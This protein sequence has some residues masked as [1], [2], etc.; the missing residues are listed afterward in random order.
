M[1]VPQYDYGGD[2]GPATLGRLHYPHGVAVDPEGCIYI[3]DLANKRI[4]KVAPPFVFAG[5][6]VGGD[7]PYAE[8]NSL[9]HI[10]SGAGRKGVRSTLSS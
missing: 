7:I 5:L 8:E 10:M 1:D 3:A 2:G 4:R 6:M 9:G